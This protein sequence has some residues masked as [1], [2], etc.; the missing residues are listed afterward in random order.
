MNEFKEMFFLVLKDWDGIE[1]LKKCA[2]SGTEIKRIYARCEKFSKKNRIN[3]H[4]SLYHIIP[5]LISNV[6]YNYANH[7]ILSCKK[8]Y[9]KRAFYN[10]NEI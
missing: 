9:Y 2:D 10:L 8:P 1:K 5:E 3:L 4:D 6:E 7:G